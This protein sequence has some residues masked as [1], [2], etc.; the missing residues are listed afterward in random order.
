[1]RQRLNW[2]ASTSSSLGKA[3]APGPI[4]VIV[5]TVVGSS[6]GA[7]P[8]VPGYFG[9]LRRICDEYGAVLILDEVMVP[10]AAARCLPASRTGVVPDMITMAK[11]LGGGYL[12]IGAMLAH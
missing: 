3:S 12:P 6:L 4:A 11:G 1:M 7:V 2:R 9:H 10:G 8:S 5:E